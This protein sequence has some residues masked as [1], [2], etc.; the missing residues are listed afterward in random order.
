MSVSLVELAQGNHARVPTVVR[1]AK[2]GV[3]AHEGHEQ[4]YDGG[5]CRAHLQYNLCVT[6]IAHNYNRHAG[7]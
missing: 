7:I 3:D 5:S 4:S 1:G 6:E 2:V